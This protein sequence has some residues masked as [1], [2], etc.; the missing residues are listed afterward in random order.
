M[1]MDWFLTLFCRLEMP[2]W[3]SKSY[4]PSLKMRLGNLDEK[5]RKILLASCFPILAFCK[6]SKKQ[7]SFVFFFKEIYALFFTFSGVSW[8]WKEKDMWWKSEDSWDIS[9]QHL[10]LSTWFHQIISMTN[11]NPLA[12]IFYSSLTFC[13]P[14]STRDMENE[15]INY[16]VETTDHH[17]INS[18]LMAVIIYR[19]TPNSCYIFFAHQWHCLKW[20]VSFSRKKP[21]TVRIGYIDLYHQ[22]IAL[23]K[24][25]TFK[26]LF[27]IFDGLL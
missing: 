12:H 11:C 1:Q 8:P 6:L 19:L 26:S 5:I 24:L 3:L 23:V 13:F 27:I 9:H 16:G 2:L 17:Q 4:F 18:S 10:P 20:L 25:G 14:T 7:E 15:L 21:R 22:A